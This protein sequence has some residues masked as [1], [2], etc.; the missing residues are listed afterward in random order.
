MSHQS[1]YHIDRHKSPGEFS[2]QPFG[3]GP[4]SVSQGVLPD[5]GLRGYRTR[6]AISLPVCELALSLSFPEVHPRAPGVY[7]TIRN[8]SVVF[9]GERWKRRE[10]NS[11]TAKSNSTSKDVA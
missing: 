3:L 6:N 10:T 4:W 7:N 8:P 1:A 9:C 11:R 2:S 5:T